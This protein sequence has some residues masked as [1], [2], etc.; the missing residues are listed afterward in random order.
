MWEW[1]NRENFDFLKE[2]YE[3]LIYEVTKAQ[4]ECHS[5]R[6]IRRYCKLLI[7]NTEVGAIEV[8]S[9]LTHRWFLRNFFWSKGWKA[10]T[11]G[12]SVFIYQERADFEEDTPSHLDLDNVLQGLKGP[13]KTDP[14]SITFKREIWHVLQE[15]NTSHKTKKMCRWTFRPRKW[16]WRWRWC[17]KW[18]HISSI[19]SPHKLSKGLEI[20]LARKDYYF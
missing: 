18:N 9:Y 19:Y 1:K 14:H 2:E 4:E 7:R 11:D 12:M 10:A 17:G 20:L 8:P 6:F 15:Q 16:R 13:M 5:A 3:I